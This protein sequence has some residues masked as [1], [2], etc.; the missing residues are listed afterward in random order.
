MQKQNLRLKQFL[1]IG[2]S[3]NLTMIFDKSAPLNTDECFFCLRMQLDI[4]VNVLT[5]ILPSQIWYIPSKR[6]DFFSSF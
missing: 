3:L 6:Y 5:N 2:I 4:V 1:Q